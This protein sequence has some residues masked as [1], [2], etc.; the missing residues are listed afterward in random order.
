M[1]QHDPETR[2]RIAAVALGLDVEEF[3]RGMIGRYLMARADEECEK[4]IEEFKKVDARDEL[5]VR[6][7]QSRML[8]P[9]RFKQ[10]LQDAVQG[11]RNAEA[12]QKQ[13]DDH[14]DGT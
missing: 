14:G 2:E 3:L 5:L 4:A 13:L 1:A 12:L 10:W 9:E 6:D 7:I 8:I 11:G